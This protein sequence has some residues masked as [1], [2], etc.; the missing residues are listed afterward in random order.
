MPSLCAPLWR[1]GITHPHTMPSVGLLP[2]LWP[3]A[4]RLHLS[5]MHLQA[6]VTH[7]PSLGHAKL[8]GRP[9][10]C[11]MLGFLGNMTSAPC[12]VTMGSA[13]LLFP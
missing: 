8:I 9:L 11:Y 10:Y 12:C 2:P 13:A 3:L 1:T 6:E 4:G 5:V 7:L